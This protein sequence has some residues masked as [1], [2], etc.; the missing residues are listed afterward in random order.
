MSVFNVLNEEFVVFLQMD[1]LLYTEGE[2]QFI[3][4]SVGADPLSLMYIVHYIY[5]RYVCMSV[6]GCVCVCAYA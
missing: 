4:N 5:Y 6:Y 1:F 2:G 3:F